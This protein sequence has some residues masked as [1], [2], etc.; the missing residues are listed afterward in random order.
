M[1]QEDTLPVEEELKVD[2]FQAQLYTAEA[3]GAFIGS[4]ESFMQ[5][6]SRPSSLREEGY[7]NK[8]NRAD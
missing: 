4:F 7:L 3:N 2:P 6:F 1:T 8:T 5:G